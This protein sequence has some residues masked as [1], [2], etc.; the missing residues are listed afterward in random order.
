MG[1]ATAFWCVFFAFFVFFVESIEWGSSIHC[2]RRKEISPCTCSLDSTRYK[3]VIKVTCEGMANFQQVITALKDNFEKTVYIELKIHDSTL[4]DLPQL[5]FQQLGLNISQLHLIHNNLS[6]LP[7]SVFA[8]LSETETLS[9]TDN[10]LNEI[11]QQ[12]LRLMPRI[13]TLDLNG[14]QIVNITS[15]DFQGLK[16]MHTLTMHGNSVRKL[17]VNSLPPTIRYLSLSSNRIPNLNGALRK[18]KDL[19]WLFLSNNDLETLDGE[20]PEIK[21]PYVDNTHLKILRVDNNRLRSVPQELRQFRNL[22]ILAMSSNQI[23]SLDGA[24]STTRL[25]DELDLSFNNI[26]VLYPYDFHELLNLD[27]IRLG[28]NRISN[29]NGSLLPL[30]NLR[31]LNLTHNEIVDFNLQEIRGLRKI[32]VLDASHNKIRVISGK[33]GN[34]VEPEP[35]VKELMMEY[36][37]L[38]YLR[39]GLTGFNG[40]QR[41]ILR[42]NLLEAITPDDIRGLDDLLFLDISYNHLTTLDGTSQVVLP[43]LE[44]LRANHNW[45]VSLETDFDC[46]PKLCWAEFSH[47]RISSVSPE[48]A[49]KTQC[50]LYGV[51]STLRIYLQGNPA[52]CN[53]E[54]ISAIKQLES[55]NNTK[56]HG[57]SECPPT[58]PP[59][60][61]TTSTTTT[62][63][64][65]VFEGQKGTPAP[66]V[67]PVSVDGAPIEVDTSAIERQP[68][69]QTTSST[70]DPATTTLTPPAVTSATTHSVV[71]T[72]PIPVKQKTTPAP[73]KQTVTEKLQIIE[74]SEQMP[75]EVVDVVYPLT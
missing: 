71:H 26:S 14:A 3:K 31:E 43:A 42:H 51:N 22:K 25:L 19:E 17:D 27:D 68:N 37:E 11:P 44:E 30:K 54:A 38:R 66:P 70:I 20:L 41:V 64:I 6:A 13:K 4:D 21:P 55:R 50:R 47:N 60:V 32:E 45:M 5:S 53:E 23:V 16:I 49:K 69:N 58:P 72:P 18:I 35:K 73:P 48:L 52:M 62:A 61:T 46:L 39:A 56:V 28:H 8:G 29:L 36:N 74:I 65:V 1:S 75:N 40:L 59:V 34:S 9:L 67:G 24:L 10:P 12:I 63:P 57:I 33:F 2:A 15:T 7:E